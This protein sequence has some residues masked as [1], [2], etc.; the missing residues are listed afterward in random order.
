MRLTDKVLAPQGQGGGISS[1]P[2]SGKNHATLPSDEGKTPLQG[3]MQVSLCIP[4]LSRDW[5]GGR[6]PVIPCTKWLQA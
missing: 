2:L 3:D 6:K 1:K 4:S 5:T